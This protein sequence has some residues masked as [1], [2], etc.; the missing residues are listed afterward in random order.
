MSD[1]SE[2]FTELF[3]GTGAILGG[4][5]FLIIILA[6]AYKNRAGAF[7]SIPVSL[8]IAIFYFDNLTGD[9]NLMWF[10]VL[11]LCLPVFLGYVAIQ[12]DE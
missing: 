3:L 1:A 8:I 9:N 2:I 12:H 7:C 11:F 6:L 4:L 5:L 10:G